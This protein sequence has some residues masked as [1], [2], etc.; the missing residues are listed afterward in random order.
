VYACFIHLIQILDS[1]SDA[2][3]TPKNIVWVVSFLDGRQLGEIF[4]SPE[5][6]WPVAHGVLGLAEV[7]PLTS[8][9]ENKKIFNHNTFMASKRECKRTLETRLVLMIT[10]SS[11]HHGW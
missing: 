8:L 9:E 11:R 6:V 2:M 5:P 3:T 10:L 1:V 7:G 4:R